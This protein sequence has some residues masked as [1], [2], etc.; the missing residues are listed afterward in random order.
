[1]KVGRAITW[2]INC[3]GRAA[4]DLGP[5]EVRSVR[6]YVAILSHCILTYFRVYNTAPGLGVVQFLL[7]AGLKIYFC[8]D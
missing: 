2:R 8:I 1:M 6:Y 7:A 3:G 5:S 4:A